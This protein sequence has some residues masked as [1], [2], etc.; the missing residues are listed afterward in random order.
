[1]NWNENRETGNMRMYQ[2]PFYGMM[3][4]CDESAKDQHK[5]I[6]NENE[7]VFY[8]GIED[9]LDKINYYLKNDSQRIKIAKNGFN[10][11]IKDYNK[12]KVWLDFLNWTLSISKL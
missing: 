8:R 2:A 10:R 6:F 9:A 7:A 5:I 11:A 1:M 3:L 12:D 4:V